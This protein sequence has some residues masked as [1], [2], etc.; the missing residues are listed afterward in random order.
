MMIKILK[1][2]LIGILILHSCLSIADIT[3]YSAGLSYLGESKN[4]E[5]AAPYASKIINNKQ[6][7]SEFNIR[8]FSELGKTKLEGINIS[9]SMGGSID[10]GK[11]LAISLA[12]IEEDF[13]VL[14]DAS[15]EYKY[16]IN[17][18][19]FAQIVLFDSNDNQIISTVPFVTN[20]IHKT[21]TQPDDQERTETYKKIYYDDNEINP[22]NQ[23]LEKL[24]KINFEKPFNNWNIKV[25]N[26]NFMPNA[27]KN[28]ANYVGFDKNKRSVQD[29][30]Y[31]PSDTDYQIDFEKYNSEKQQ[32]KSRVA[33]QFS[34]D[35]SKNLRI[36]ILP[37][38][39][40]D[41]QGK[42]ALKFEDGIR[43]LQLPNA[44]F[45][46]DIDLVGFQKRELK[47][48]KDLIIWLSYIS[49]LDLSIGE[50]C[51]N[52]SDTI[53]FNEKGQLGVIKTL[54]LETYKK[55]NGK[56]VEWSWYKDA[57]T[58]LSEKYA[59]QLLDPDK[60]WVKVHMT[61][62]KSFNKFK[63]NIKNLEKDIF[64]HLR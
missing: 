45:F 56:E 50:V 43:K 8:L 57:I 15:D 23:F 3:V 60:K 6:R 47:Q 37:F 30:D 61:S 38:T 5:R 44:D 22:I 21:N 64:R 48:H 19:T 20:F 9:N 16:T 42:M 40:T 29:N 35:I 26:V 10:E 28:T 31:V 51:N 52:C 62:V 1:R 25:R 55:S 49:V 14:E 36:P 13:Q 34:S 17:A 59:L 18:R 12:I 11:S 24:P 58:I 53:K 54:P 63:K 2:T 32:L 27:K 7:L 39:M 33:N 46:I 4:L 41:T